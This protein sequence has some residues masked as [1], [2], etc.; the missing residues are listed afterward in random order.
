MIKL[1]DYLNIESVETVWPDDLGFTLKFKVTLD[2]VPYS[3]HMQ[4][5]NLDDEAYF[6]DAPF[7]D[8]KR[9]YSDLYDLLNESDYDLLLSKCRAIYKEK[10]GA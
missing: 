4:T 10:K 1:N 2:D 5:H 3:L 9:D 7:Y 6:T 8:Y